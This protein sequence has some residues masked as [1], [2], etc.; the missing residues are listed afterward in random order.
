[1]RK[2]KI[3]IGISSCLLGEEVR[4]D[5]GHKRDR[6]I[7]DRLSDYISFVPI[8][9]EVGIGLGVPRQP[10]Q[11]VGSPN[12]Y[13][14]VGVKDESLDVTEDL[15]RYAHATL[16]KLSNVSGYIFKSKSP[17]CG[18]ARVKLF[19][20]SSAVP[21]QEGTGVY[22]KTVMQ[23][24]PNLPVEEEGRLNDPVLRE[25]FIERI[26]VYRRWQNLVEQGITAGRLVE[27]YTQ[28]KLT[29]LS[30]GQRGYMRLG[31][32][33]ATVGRDNFLDIADQFIAELMTVLKRPATRRS[34]ANVLRHV[35]GYL[36]KKLD[37]SDKQE[38]SH[39]LEQY[40]LGYLPLIVPIT[41]L[42]HHF[43]RNPT[44]YLTKQIYLNPHPPELMLRNSL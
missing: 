31:R 36:K 21:K 29:V 9:P 7:T 26:F 40:R 16:A 44:Q 15:I 38:L 25:N 42:R 6:F 30:H 43:R 32:L 34:H 33:V 1:M 5:G 12:K 10:I 11:L 19:P 28:H 14:V 39:T 13:K 22:A 20:T 3:K 8:C 27:F 24:L 4:F 23:L 2:R 41:L 18:M 17:S 35:Q 37:K